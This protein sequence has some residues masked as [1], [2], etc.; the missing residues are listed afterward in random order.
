MDR[1]TQ[2]RIFEPFFTTKEKGKGTGLGLSTVYGIVKQSGGH[3]SVSSELGEGTTF[4]I[5]LPRTEAG[6]E[7]SERAR[8]APTTLEGTETSCSSKT[9]SKCEPCRHDPPQTRLPRARGG[10][11]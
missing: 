3:V 7:R 6:A 1:A 5:Y 10:N 9:M 2:A 8:R 4:K 11:G